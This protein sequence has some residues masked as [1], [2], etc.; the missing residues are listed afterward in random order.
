MSEAFDVSE[1]SQGTRTLTMSRSFAVPVQRLFDAWADPAQTCRWM[2]PRNTDC[3]VDEWDFR[4]GGSYLIVMVSEEGNEFPA[5][6]VFRIID[7]PNRL[8]MT[9]A[10]QHE[11]FMQGIDTLLDL[12]FVTA[13][14]GASELRLT[15]ALMP[16]EEQAGRHAGGWGSAL[17]CLEEFLAA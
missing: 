7:P 12:E 8:A 4:E 2:G 17:E 16:D 9:W 15:H 10:W 11:D 5:K 13:G 1:D 6:G 14:D 3:R